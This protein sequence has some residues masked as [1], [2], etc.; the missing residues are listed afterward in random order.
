MRN[1]RRKKK[2]IAS[3]DLV[4]RVKD[5]SLALKTDKEQ[6]ILGSKSDCLLK[7]NKIYDL[8]DKYHI[9]PKR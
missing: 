1:N 2:K 9:D 3:L 8:E 5:I 7:V 6:V 4:L